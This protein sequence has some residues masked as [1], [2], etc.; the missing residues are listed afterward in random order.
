MFFSAGCGER[1]RTSKYMYF[2]KYHP[3]KEQLQTR[4]LTEKEALPYLVVFS[5][6]T[7]LICSLPIFDSFNQWDG[8]SALVNVSIAVW[9]AIYVYRENGGE[10]GFDFIQK[11][12]VLGWVVSVRFLCAFMPAMIVISII[13]EAF[14]LTSIDG[15]Q[16][17]DALVAAVA[18]II[19]YE[20]LGRHIKDTTA[21]ATE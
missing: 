20:R 21:K 2:I 16:P 15:T 10:E 5:A 1:E 13:G 7:T 17:Y 19:F 6:L 8:V 11:F 3:L 4:T 9:G 18:E 14:G 12:V